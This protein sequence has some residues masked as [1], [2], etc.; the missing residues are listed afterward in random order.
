[1]FS[2]VFKTLPPFFDVVWAVLLVVYLFINQEDPS[3]PHTEEQTVQV[4]SP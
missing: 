3:K 4:C 2:F 1:M